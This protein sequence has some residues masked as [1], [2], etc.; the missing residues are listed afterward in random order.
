MMGGF[1]VEVVF[2][3][4]VVMVMLRLELFRRAVD[5]RPGD[6]H[7][8][9]DKYKKMLREC[10]PE[11]A[12]SLACIVLIIA[13]RSRGDTV[14]ESM[15]E[16]S[17]Q[18]WEDIKNQWPLLLTADTLLAMQVMVRVVVVFS[19]VLRAGSGKALPVS[20]E[21]AM[22]WLAGALARIGVLM[23]SEAYWLEGPAGGTIPAVLEVALVPLLLV[24]GHKALCRCPL[25]GLLVASLVGVFAGRHHLN[26][27]DEQGANV[28]FMAAHGFEFLA[29]FAYVVRTMFI[30]N[31][32]L[33]G[34]DL[35]IAF[36][37]ILMPLQT[38]FSVYFWLQ[39]FE[40]DAD[41]VGAGIGL[42]AIQLSCLAQL[43]A[44]LAAAA[45]QAAAWFSDD[46]PPR[47]LAATL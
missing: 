17:R 15:D 42:Q 39:A 27:A 44:Y 18:A 7:Q 14:S 41:L 36:T 26:I 5:G 30:D 6:R 8:S 20:E 37:H 38:S 19:A 43:G 28:C 47:A 35:N 11:A 2:C 29:A 21:T 16:Q 34:N 40:P 22:L 23:Q 46:A 10:A 4:A 12:G 45:L 33:V 3:V 32:G 24:L 13:L 31:E 9:T 1:N 25:T